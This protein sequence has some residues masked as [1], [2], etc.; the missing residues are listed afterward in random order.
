MTGENHD[1]SEYRDLLA[2]LDAIDMSKRKE[3]K[4][5]VT[6]I[7]DEIYYALESSITD[8]NEV[9]ELSGLVDEILELIPYDLF[10]S[11]LL[12]DIE[13]KKNS[14]NEPERDYDEDFNRDFGGG[15]KKDDDASIDE[16][17]T[18]LRTFSD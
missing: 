16:M 10:K 9:E 8:E 3:E 5:L 18:S 15:F 12:S 1:I 2:M 13:E 17:M 7:E 4:S 14:F 6:R 11:D